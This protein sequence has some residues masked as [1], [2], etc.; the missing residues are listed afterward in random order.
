AARLD[1]DAVLARCGPDAAPRA[2]AFGVAHALDLV[3]TRDRVAYVLRVREWLLALLRKRERAVGQVVL[4]SRGQHA[5]RGVR[6]GAPPW[7]PL[8]ALC[9]ASLLE[10]LASSLFLLRRRHGSPLSV[11]R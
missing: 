9:G 11:S 1:L 5:A 6:R 3:E 4:P 2:V 10:I 7:P 8:A